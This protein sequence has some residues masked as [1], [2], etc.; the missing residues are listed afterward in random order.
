MRKVLL[1]LIMLFL[2]LTLPALAQDA[3]DIT[4]ECTLVRKSKKVDFTPMTDRNYATSFMMVPRRVLEARSEKNVS[5]IYLQFFRYTAQLEI[6]TEVDGQW[7]SV[8]NTSGK[9]LTEWIPLPEGTRNIRIINHNRQRVYLAE[10]TIFGEGDRPAYVHQWHDLD[11]AD[12]MLLVTHP[13]DDLLWFGGLLP[14]Y[15]GERK[16]KVQV[17]Y[18]AP[19]VGHRRLELLDGIWHCG[20]TAYPVFCNMQDLRA[21][22]L[23]KQYKLWNKDKLFERVV[24]VLREKKP[25]VLVTQD[26]K[27][28]YG[29][30]A[31]R[32][33]ADA[34]M[35]AVTLAADPNRYRSSAKEHGTWQVKKLYLHLYPDNQLKMDWHVPLAAFGGKDG[36]T[37]AT[38]AMACHVSQVANGW[39]M[40]EGGRFDNSLFGLYFTSVGPDVEKNDLMENIVL[41]Q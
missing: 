18:L 6:Q 21:P 10:L 26:E 41:D 20:V 40:E 22:T 34:C 14:T 9:Y 33:C 17:V 19:S 35:N 28:E 39:V 32:A 25:E 31:H 15:A 13:D 16:L 7:Q 3:E 1:P 8:G 4:L 24:A 27:G 11:K 2:L 29:H 5:A 12:L 38:E 23:I 36:M 37:I 30:G